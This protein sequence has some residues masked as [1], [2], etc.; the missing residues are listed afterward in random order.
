MKDELLNIAADVMERALKLGATAADAMAVERRD[1]EVS[2]RQGVVEELVQAEAKE[3]GLRVFAGN[4]SAMIAGSVLTSEALQ[5]LAERCVAM[6]KLAPPDP[7][8][9]LA[10]PEQLA[11]GDID[12]DLVSADYASADKLK[13][14]ATEAENAALAVPG[15]SRSNGAGASA[16]DA[17]IALVA[18]NGFSRS[19]RRTGF[20]MSASVIAGEGTGMERDYDGTSANHFSDLETPE[21]IGRTAGERATR[22][23]NPHKL[24]SRSVPVIYD[25]RVASSLLGHLSGAI[26]GG[27]IARGVSFLKEDL[28]K[29]IFKP[30]INIIDDPLRPRG[31]SSRSFD[32]EGLPVQRRA[33]IDKGVLTG[34][35]LDLRSARQLGLPP[36]GNGARG[37]ASPPS[38]STSNLHLEA[39]TDSPK[40]MIK[41]IGTGLLITEFIGSSINSATGDY[42]R[43]ASGYWFENGEI[44]YPVSEITVAG[45][46]RDM[47]LSLTPASDLLF[48]GS[49]NAP[50]CLIEGMTIAGR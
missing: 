23:V 46:L 6:A 17:T 15:V 43:G 25:R 11:K 42:S 2:I 36:T 13:A 50:S 47:F 10:S 29:A 26:N 39:G 31:P 4:S 20:G 34:W 24:S 14:M 16:S 35:V 37:L 33:L 22:R 18:S 40:D 8:S 28:G 19:Y 3:I 41:G 49:T 12:L 27:S 45:N 30:G 7:H 1:T 21:K 9:G 32:G 5:R 38:A 48:R 44:L